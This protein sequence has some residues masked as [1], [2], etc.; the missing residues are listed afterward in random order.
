MGVEVYLLLK[1][2]KMSG[3]IMALMLE[4]K[5]FNTCCPQF[6]NFNGKSHNRSIF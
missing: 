3:S 2:E 6:G 5:K 4:W 1:Y